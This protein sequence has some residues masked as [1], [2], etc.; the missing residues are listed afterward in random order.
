M[1]V[2]NLNAVRRLVDIIDQA[3]DCDAS[4]MS[5]ASTITTM[6]AVPNNNLVAIVCREDLRERC[7]TLQMVLDTQED[8]WTFLK[9]L[10]RHV[11]NT[12]CRPDP[13]QVK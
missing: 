12:L 8:K 1:R 3:D 5:T 11:S 6:A 13:D 9:T 4:V 10:C 2:I 7:Y